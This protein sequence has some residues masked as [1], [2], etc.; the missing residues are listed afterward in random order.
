MVSE[1]LIRKKA[2]KIQER[3]GM[4]LGISYGT[5]KM[6]VV[7]TT[8]QA[9]TVLKD[10]YK[11]G[12]KAFVLP[13]ELF[14]A[15]QSATDLYKTEYGNILKIRDEAKKYNIELA[16]RQDSLSQEPD[17][18]IKAFA[19]ISSVMDCRTFLVN[20]AFY[21]KI[22]P[23]DQAL[24]LTVYKINEI[25]SSL[26]AE[27]KIALETTGRMNEVGSLE[28]VLDMVKRTQGTEPA[29]NWGNIHSRG[30]GALRSQRDFE[31][32]LNQVRSAVGSKWLEEAYFFFSGSSYGPSGFIKTIPI[33]RADIRLEHMIRASMSFNVKGTLIIDDPE[34][35]RYILKNLDSLADMV[36]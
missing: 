9:L 7:R 35:E 16:V 4:R 29:L 13:K 32:V 19:T 34:K 26:R 11:I 6:P 23:R 36:R 2:L 15:I 24:R 12:L 8:A 3:L 28:D 27:T 17:E 33:D 25:V 31:L 10:L 20:P 18:A 14:F 30:A 21:S 5:S 22:M 1:M